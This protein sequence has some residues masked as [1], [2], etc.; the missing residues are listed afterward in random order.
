MD[1]ND[2]GY[3]GRVV[4]YAFFGVFDAMWQTTIY[5]LL[6]AMSN[7]PAKLAHFSGFCMFVAF[8]AVWLPNFLCSQINHC[9]LQAVQVF[10]VQMQWTLR[11]S[12]QS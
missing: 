4:L 12:N 10:G 7:D 11:E 6:G 3:P 5:W 8:I 9:S 2:P 1:M